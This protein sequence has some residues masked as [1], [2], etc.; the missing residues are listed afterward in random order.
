MAQPR[1]RRCTGGPSGR[2]RAPRASRH[3]VSAGGSQGMPMSSLGAMVLLSPPADANLAERPML[4]PPIRPSRPSAKRYWAMCLSSLEDSRCR[5]AGSRTAA[6]RRSAARARAA[7]R[8]RGRCRRCAAD[9]AGDQ[10]FA[11]EAVEPGLVIGRRAGRSWSPG[12]GCCPDARRSAGSPV[13][14]VF[15]TGRTRRM[16]RSR[17]VEQRRSRRP[18]SS[19]RRRRAAG[20]G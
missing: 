14:S 12:S 9:L 6:R 13:P 4:A 7:G 2:G 5:C 16:L 1:R 3:S 10:E 11:A 18:R 19:R 17:C 20:R 8:S 15:S